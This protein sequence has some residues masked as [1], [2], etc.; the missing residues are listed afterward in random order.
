MVL[1]IVILITLYNLIQIASVSQRSVGKDNKLMSFN[2]IELEYVRSIDD[3]SM[4]KDINSN[5]YIFYDNKLM[6]LNITDDNYSEYTLKDLL[7]KYNI[8]LENYKL[9]KDNDEYLYIKYINDIKTEDYIRISFN[10]DKIKKFKTNKLG[11]FDNL[12]INFSKDELIE[13]IYSKYNVLDNIKDIVIDYKDKYVVV[14]YLDD[15]KEL[16]YEL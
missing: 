16:I 9:F 15:D 1:V 3:I 4:Y 13:R 6:E 10:E 7:N 8:D 14:C 12:V 5:E 2:E 11:L